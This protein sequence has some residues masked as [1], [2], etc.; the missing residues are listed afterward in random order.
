MRRVAAAV[1][2]VECLHAPRR[3]PLP[4]L[5]ES[6]DNPK[7][8]DSDVGHE[9]VKASCEKALAGRAR[10]R[11]RDALQGHVRLMTLRSSGPCAFG[12]EPDGGVRGELV[13]V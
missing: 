7:A 12:C 1:R 3:L 9:L 2:F 5:W 13:T 10:M 8:V 6:N 4:N 11:E